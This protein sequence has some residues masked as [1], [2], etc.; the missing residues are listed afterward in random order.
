MK[1]VFVAGAW[2]PVV[3]AQV[4]VA[5]AWKAVATVQAY[6]GAWK[7]AGSYAPPMTVTAP[8]VSG[9]TSNATIRTNP[10]T[11]TPA[12]GTGPYTYSW[13]KLSGQGTADT[14]TS[15]T[16]TFTV[17]GAFAGYSDTGVY[18]VTVTDA[19]ATTAQATITATFVRYA[20]GGFL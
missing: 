1:Q 17:A 2:K 4:F 19:R 16:T 18:Q 15:A 6:Q 8:D 9:Y 5:G 11:A 13:V 3:S 10:T 20:A 7:D 14:P 12:G